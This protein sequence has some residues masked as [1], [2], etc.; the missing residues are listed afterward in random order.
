[1]AQKELSLEN[2][3]MYQPFVVQASSW[4]C[5]GTNTYFVS[6]EK[7]STYQWQVDNGSGNFV[8][9]S[10][11][12]PYSNIHTATLTLT[13]PT[14]SLYGYKFRCLVNGNVFSN[15]FTLKFVSFW[16]GA[17]STAWE[18]AGNWNCGSVPDGNTDVYI[19]AG[20]PRYPLVN[21]IR[22][23]RSVNLQYGTSVQVAAG[24]QLTITGK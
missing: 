1:M 4:I 19:N 6:N 16:T 18:N 14:T 9:L 22:A 12:T 21:S 3:F 7:G 20:K 23:A 13:A 8:N 24:Q 5:A 15:I 11:T 2:N 10:N 17:T